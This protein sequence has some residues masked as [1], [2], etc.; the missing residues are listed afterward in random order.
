MR[1]RSREQLRPASGPPPIVLALLALEGVVVITL[2]LLGDSVGDILKSAG[3][4]VAVTLAFLNPTFQELGRR[5][6][7][8]SIV[9]EGSDGE[10][11]VNAPALR[12]WP[13]DEERIV[14]NELAGARE[15]LDISPA[16]TTMMFASDPFAIKPSDR[17]YQEAREAFEAELAEYETELREWLAQYSAA[18]QQRSLIFE[19]MIA[20]D[21]KRGAAH[22][23]GVTLALELP[24]SVSVIDDWPTVGLPPERPSYEPP[25]PRPAP[26]MHSGAGLGISRSL[27]A[28]ASMGSRRDL[29]DLTRSMLGAP[30]RAFEE[31]DW[32]V[33]STEILE[34]SIGDV[35]CD[36]S[37]SVRESLL[38]SVDGPGLH[39]IG[40]VLYSKSASR[41]AHGKIVLAVPDD[42]DRPAFGRLAGITSFP[43]VPIVDEDGE[44]V[45]D[46]RA[47]DPP[48][49]PELEQPD[50]EDLLE[51]LSQAG[52]LMAW[53][54]L[55]LDPASDG[56][57]ASVVRVRDARQAGSCGEE[58]DDQP[59][60]G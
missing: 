5:K 55:C 54:A 51:Y 45:H 3:P 24:A 42:H 13:I 11:V 17:E 19:L 34:T 36:R 22:A 38:V 49:R 25:Q 46:V 16:L 28:P 8:L 23:E 29:V 6:P 56:S 44:V 20:V 52:E 31:S 39:E 41:P 2:A 27:V 37:V 48:A 47:S 15:S 12:P 7:K 26:W 18:A 35:H 59:T 14:S 33:I 43:D 30:G 32:K 9:V 53:E 21:N 57:Y 1:R 50:R 58:A 60:A 10:G 4:A 40:W